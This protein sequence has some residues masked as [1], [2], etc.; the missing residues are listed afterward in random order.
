MVNHANDLALAGERDRAR[1]VEAVELDRRAREFFV[2]VLGNDHYDTIGVTAN[3]A[4]G[5]RAVG[6]A[7]EAEALAAEALRRAR[8]TLGEDHPTTR[9][10]LAGSRLDSDIEPPTT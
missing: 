4:L 5:L 6:R 1:L 10:V 2:E 7:E 9:A 3:L 8:E